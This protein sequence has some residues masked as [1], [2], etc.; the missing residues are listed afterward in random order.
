MAG[1]LTVAAIK[2]PSRITT[3][4]SQPDM[5]T[6]RSAIKLTASALAAPLLIPSRLLGENAPSNLIRLAQI[7]TGRMGHGDMKEAATRGLAMGARVVAVCDVDSNRAKHAAHKLQGIY[8]FQLKDDRPTIDVY[9][10][11]RELLARKDIDGVVISTPDHQHAVIAVAAANAGKDIYL[12]KPLTYSI[13]EGRKLVEAVRRKK[14]ILQTG[15]Q[16]R[17][18]P[19]FRLACE[20]ALGG[21]LGKLQRVELALPADSGVG[22]ADPM[23]VPANLDYDMW[24]GPA[25]EVPYTEDRVHPQQE[26]GRPGWL[27]IEQY[28]RGMITGWGAHMYDIAQW[29]IGADRDSGPVSV[30]ATAR[31]PDRGLFNV[32]T[33][34]EAEAEYAN[35]VKLISRTGIAEVKFIGSD[36]WVRVWRG[37]FEAHAPELLKLPEQR[38]R[39]YDSDLHMTDFLDAMRSRKDPVCPVE[40]GHRSNSLCIIHHIAMKLGRKLKWNLQAQEF[41]DDA[42]AN[43]ML[44]FEHRKP[45]LV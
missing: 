23:P 25:A 20:L 18:D 31:F 28:C 4:T 3:M 6:R 22:K 37:G 19:R 11:Y 44:D 26:F 12:Q 45:W 9:G 39:R 43:S 30:S 40:I 41:V 21:R 7:G 14:V 1:D 2:N 34:Y 33:D 16:Q 8:A 24:L 36:G 5:L 15:S 29:G 17:S 38:R 42:Q 13:G 27:Q 32:H 10:D 35:G